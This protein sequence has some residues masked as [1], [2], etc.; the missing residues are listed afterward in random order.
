MNDETTNQASW[1]IADE[2]AGLPSFARIICEPGLSQSLYECIDHWCPPEPTGCAE[3]DFVE[4]RRYGRAALD[5]A[6]KTTGATF[7][8]Y[9]VM[10][11]ER[12]PAGDLER[13]FIAE[14]MGPALRA[15]LPAIVPDATLEAIDAEGLDIVQMREI[16]RLVR[17]AMLTGKNHPAAFHEMMFRLLDWS[18]G[19]WIGA[20]VYSFVT[21]A[22]NGV[23]D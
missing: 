8:V 13:G 20:G 23:L 9:V 1:S 7:L 14:L 11:M 6:R 19:R 4:G 22:C 5:F 12:K 10:S 16:E 3:V 15:R 18:Y 17:M 21:A 2:F